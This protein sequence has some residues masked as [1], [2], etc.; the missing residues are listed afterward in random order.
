MSDQ[1]VV[2]AGSADGDFVE[3]FITAVAA[4]R[5]PERDLHAIPA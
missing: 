5:H 4:H 1:G 2:T 3:A